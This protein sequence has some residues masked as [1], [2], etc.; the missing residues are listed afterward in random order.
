MTAVLDRAGQ[1]L[2]AADGQPLVRGDQCTPEAIAPGVATTIN[3]I[4]R[5]DVEPGNPGQTGSRAYV[6]GHQIAGKTGTSQD[7]FSAAF[8]GYTPEITA[9]VM[10]LN[11]KLNQDVGGFGGNK[12]AT[13]WR[14]AMA[15]ILDARGS[16]EFPPADPAVVNGNTR[17]VPGCGSVSSCRTALADAG[18]VPQTVTVDGSTPSGSL[19][20]TSPRPA[21]ARWSARWS[22]SGSATA[23]PTH[24]GAGPRTR[25]PGTR[26]GTTG[27]GTG[28]PGRRPAVHPRSAHQLTAR[29]VHDCGGPG[30]PE[31]TAV[32]HSTRLRGGRGS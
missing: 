13:I 22:P 21:G 19:L 9:S 15:P 11:P 8:V 17:P 32:V 12:P 1:P 6:A 29:Q 28:R 16:G 27:T 4:L 25:A 10:V 31:T 23:P 24:P 30:A 7:N 26:T 2:L 3:Q 5:R 20:G 14:A 18:F